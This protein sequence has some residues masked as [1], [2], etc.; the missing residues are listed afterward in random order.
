MMHGYWNRRKRGQG[1]DNELAGLVDKT[2]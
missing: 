1:G 2:I